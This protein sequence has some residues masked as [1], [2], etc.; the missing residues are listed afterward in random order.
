ML[1]DVDQAA[2]KLNVSKQSIY[3][4]LKL[5][6]YKEYIIRKSGKTYIDDDLLNLIKDNLKFK[7]TIENEK[8][9]KPAKQEDSTDTTDLLNLNKDLFNAL[10]NQLK[11]Q[12]KQLET[13]DVQIKDLNDRLAAEQ[14][15]TKNRQVLEL[16]QQDNKLLEEVAADQEPKKGFFQRIFK[17]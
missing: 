14:E 15:L 4:K 5:K 3:N 8:M 13:K 10:M 6:E 2:S 7:S 16:K 11:E 17:K 12:A 9:E 1:Y